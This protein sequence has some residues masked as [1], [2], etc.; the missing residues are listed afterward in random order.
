MTEKRTLASARLVLDY[1]P[2]VP[3]LEL[4]GHARCGVYYLFAD[5][6]HAGAVSITSLSNTNAEIGYK[7][8]PE[9]QGLGLA[10][11]AVAAVI[12][13]VNDRHTFTILSA[14]AR[15]SNEASRRVLEKAGFKRVSSKL[16]WNETGEVPSAIDRYRLDLPPPTE[17]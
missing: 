15:A 2:D 7:I 5:G 6:S 8:E 16:C 3:A 4:I 9:F 11:E 1:V 10:S 12:A 14:I 17:T 13:D